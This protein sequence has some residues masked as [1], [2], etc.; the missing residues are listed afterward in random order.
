[1][2]GCHDTTV[3]FGKSTIEIKFENQ[4]INSAKITPSSGKR[5]CCLNWQDQTGE[6]DWTSEEIFATFGR[7]AEQQILVFSRNGL[8]FLF[9]AD[10]SWKILEWH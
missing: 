3:P 5:G 6:L 1:M 10:G 8:G 7:G 4:G 2:K 9:E